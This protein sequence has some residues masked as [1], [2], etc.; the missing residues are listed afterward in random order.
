M[1]IVT[2]NTLLKEREIEINNLLDRKGVGPFN[3]AMAPSLTAEN[4]DSITMPNQDRITVEESV[5][6]LPETPKLPCC[7]GYVS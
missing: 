6:E 4:D 2:L 1:R 3:T 7:P 5:D